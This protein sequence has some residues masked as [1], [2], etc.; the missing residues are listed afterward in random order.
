MASPIL[1]C[2]AACGRVA[3]VLQHVFPTLER[4]SARKCLWIPALPSSGAGAVG[5]QLT[6]NVWHYLGRVQAFFGLHSRDGNAIFQYMHGRL[7]G[8][9]LW[10]ES[11][12]Q[13]W[14]DWMAVCPHARAGKSEHASQGMCETY[15]VGAAFISWGRTPKKYFYFVIVIFAFFFVTSW[16]GL[17]I[18]CSPHCMLSESL[19]Q[20]HLKPWHTDHGHGQNIGTWWRHQ[21]NRFG[22]RKCI[23]QRK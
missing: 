22:L 10:H 1:E 23:E 7:F 16:G 15:L 21:Q 17:R 12:D 3:F 6:A 9:A 13:C 4:P 20:Q 2:V 18:R 19:S 8:S 11:C 14:G 5:E